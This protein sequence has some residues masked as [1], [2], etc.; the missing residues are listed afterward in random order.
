MNL[1][2]MVHPIREYSDAGC[3][4]VLAPKVGGEMHLPHELYEYLEVK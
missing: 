1:G 2:Q 3:E 4:V